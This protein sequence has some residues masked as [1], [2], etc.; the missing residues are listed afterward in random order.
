MPIIFHSPGEAGKP[1]AGRTATIGAPL[2]D[3]ADKPSLRPQGLSEVFDRL[4]MPPILRYI[5]FILLT[6]TQF[7]IARSAA[8]WRS[9]CLSGALSSD[10]I[11]TL[12]SQ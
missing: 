3:R 7:V 6:R 2:Q 4:Q 8:T 5:P 9:R 12:R 1:E 11:A 10:E